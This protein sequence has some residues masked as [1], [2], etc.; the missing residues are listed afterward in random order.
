MVQR[1]LAEREEQVL[2]ENQ[3]GFHK[4]HGCIDQIFALRVLAE[5]AREFNTSLYLAFVDLWKAYDSVKHEPL[6]SVLQK[7]YLLLEK[8]IRIIRVLHRGTKCAVRAYGKV[9]GEFVITTGARKGDCL[10]LT[11]STCSLMH[12]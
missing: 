7:R 11:C 1:T 3:C 5:K 10:H 2:R 8:L 4:G 12:S 9:S 6:W